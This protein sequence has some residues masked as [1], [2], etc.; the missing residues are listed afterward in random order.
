M[1]SKK[2]YLTVKHTLRFRQDGTFRILFLTDIHAGVG[3]SAQTKPAVDAMIRYAGPDMVL[4]GGDTFGCRIG[5]TKP[6]QVREYLDLLAELLEE[7]Q[8]PWAHVYGNHD[9][10]LGVSREIQ[11]EIYESYPWCVSKRGERDISG[12]GNYVLPV[13]RSDSDEVALNIWA[14][15]AHNSMPGFDQVNWYYQTSKAIEECFG[16]KIPSIL[17]L[18]IPLPEYC[19]VIEHPEECGT[20][21]TVTG[22]FDREWE[23]SG[24][25]QAC[26]ERGDV[27]GIFC[28]HEHFHDMS[29][30][31]K[32]IRLSFGASCGYDAG[33]D[34]TLRGG[35]IIEFSEKAPGEMN[36]Y[37]VHL[38][39]I[40]GA[41]AIAWPSRLLDGPE[42]ADRKDYA[43]YADV[44]YGSEKRLLP[45]PEGIAAKWRL[46]DADQGS[47]GPAVTLPF[48]GLLAQR[49][50]ED[51]G[52]NQNNADFK[53]LGE[54][55][56][57]IGFSHMQV[58]GAG[59]GSTFFHCPLITPC[60]NEIGESTGGCGM[61]W[62]SGAPGFYKTD[63]MRNHILCEAVVAPNV[64]CHHYTYRREKGLLVLD[65]S[66]SRKKGN[67]KGLRSQIQETRLRLRG[68]T[69][70]EAG[71]IMEDRKL[72]FYGHCWNA[73]KAGL[74]RSDTELE[75]EL[76]GESELVISGA[77]QRFGVCFSE[78]SDREVELRLCVSADSVE[79]AREDYLSETRDIKEIALAAY[80]TW[81]RVLGRIEAEARVE[82]DKRLFYTNLY[83]S[84]VHPSDWNRERC[85]YGKKSDFV[86]ELMLRGAGKAQLPLIYTLYPEISEK[87]VQILIEYY[88]EEK[89]SAG[90]IKQKVL[91]AVKA[92]I[93]DACVRGVE[94]AYPA[95]LCKEA[96]QSCPLLLQNIEARVEQ[97]GGEEEFVRLLDQYFGYTDVEH[98]ASGET[99]FQAVETGT[100]ACRFSGFSD[101]SDMEAPGAYYYVGRHDRMCQIIDLG[102]R[103]MF[104]EGRNGLP[105]D[106]CLGA[107]SSFYVWYAMGLVPV[108]GQ[109]K[110]IL[111]CPRMDTVI[112]HLANDRTFEISREGEGIYVAQAYFNGRALSDFSI[113]VSDMMRGGALRL[114]MKEAGA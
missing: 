36:T 15:D 80:R 89:E 14:L 44:F 111:S 26:V 41:K 13:L 10:N 67:S 99:T 5:V 74:W 50:V 20:V 101:V 61:K 110:L 68:E 113:K 59:E 11:Q 79:A 28:G 105:G 53:N 107:L 33:S 52:R 55:V 112:L 35:R 7:R 46:S 21:G 32:G 51:S 17:Y 108:S 93:Y 2:E 92:S 88:E 109:D 69:A 96:E 24:L 23:N 30:T 73:Q 106:N 54:G 25:F 98:T 22:G 94:A 84:L 104:A 29:G 1:F 97:A 57:C 62:E 9:D 31:Y 38:R 87:L 83:H 86:T 90:Q 34:N 82:C 100:D 70:F 71:L 12:V 47:T 85:V 65:F 114:V 91:A 66:D 58:S 75:L 3:M 16:R 18:H 37:M 48:G 8:I 19:Y 56:E 63:L 77:E 103:Y 27:K 76:E 64:M 95:Q 40:C 49:V 42:G 102:M 4:I 78:F 6:E 45:K 60:Y 43:V 39:D 81:D 72:Y